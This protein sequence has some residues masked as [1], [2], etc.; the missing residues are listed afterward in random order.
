MY[1]LSIIL[2]KPH[3][4]VV[5]VYEC[6]F[7]VEYV[8]PYKMLRYWTGKCFPL[9]TTGQESYRLNSGN[10]LVRTIHPRSRVKADQALIQKVMQIQSHWNIPSI[11]TKL[12]SLFFNKSSSYPHNADDNRP[13]STCINADNECFVFLLTINSLCICQWDS[14]NFFSSLKTD[15]IMV[16]FQFCH[17]R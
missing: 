9:I 10:T 16:T 12:V 3:I 8:T 1:F 14:F 2:P 15:L 5:K 13:V 11:V 6:M 7:K 17:T 4:L